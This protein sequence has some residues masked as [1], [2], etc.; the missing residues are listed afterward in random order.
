M[1][2]AAFAAELFRVHGGYAGDQAVGWR[3]LDEIVDL[4]PPALRG[5]RQRA[6]FDEGAFV[7][8]VSDVLSG[9]P[10]IGLAPPL[11]RGRTV[12]VQRDR[13]PRDDFGKVG[14][15][16]IE[17]DIRLFSDIVAFDFGRLDKQDGFAV[18]QGGPGAA[19]DL[20][21]PAAMR[22]GDEM[23][24]LHGFEHR[25]LLAGA[26]KV[27]FADV[28]RH[29]RALQ[30]RRY[31]DRSRRSDGGLAEF[32]GGGHICGRPVCIRV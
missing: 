23:L 7:D 29:D 5:D 28:D 24:H 15:D 4:A 3:V 6:V 18:H 13:V 21:H 31:G 22:R 17:I 2:R 16:M 19:G 11:D 10:L 25:D 20:R 27:A 8:E 9:R 12:L 14:T 26:D 30:R 1:Q 32:I